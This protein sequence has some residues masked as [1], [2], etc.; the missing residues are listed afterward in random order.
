[1]FISNK[2]IGAGLGLAIVKDIVSAH[3]GTISYTSEVGRGTTF[4]LRLPVA[5]VMD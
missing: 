3:Q 2:P 1:M 5:A 4:E